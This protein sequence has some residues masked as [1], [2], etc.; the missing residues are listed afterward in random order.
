[1]SLTNRILPL[2]L[3]FLLN[4]TMFLRA[5]VLD[6]STKLVYNAGTTRY[7]TGADFLYLRANSSP[8]DT[9]I[10]NFHNYQFNY[11]NGTLYQDLGNLGTALRRVYWEQASEPGRQLGHDVFKD[12][13][14]DPEKI[15]LYNT[16]SPFTRIS[17]VQG[18]RGLQTIDAEFSRNIKPNWNFGFNVRRMVALK[19][20]GVADRSEQQFSNYGFQVQSNFT[21]KSGKYRNYIWM[22]VMHHFHFETGGILPDTGDTQDQMFDYKLENIQL[23]RTLSSTSRLQS[24]DRRTYYRSYQELSIAKNGL[25]VFHQLDFKK[26]L[27]R[28]QD[29]N[30][31]N[32]YNY[33]P[34]IFFDSTATNDQSKYHLLENKAGVKGLIGNVYYQLFARH[35]Y[36]LFNQHLVDTIRENKYEE[37]FFGGVVEY[38]RSDSVYIGVSAESGLWDFAYAA[39]LRS[40]ILNLQ[41]RSTST[42]AGIL[43]ENMYSNHAQWTKT[44]RNVNSTV[45]SASAVLKWKGQS[46]TPRA[47]YTMLDNLIYYDTT[48]APSQTSELISFMQMGG[49][50]KTGFRGL[51]MENELVYT[52]TVGPDY[53]PVPEWFYT[54]R[55]YAYGRVF[56]KVLRLQTG[57][58]ATRTSVYRTP[59]YSALLQQ[60]YLTNPNDPLA[61]VG[62]YWQANVFLNAYLKRAKFFLLVSHANQNFPKAGYFKTPYYSALGRTV[63]FGITWMFY[64]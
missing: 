28:Y 16:R 12:Y 8:I 20:I 43:Q 44:F 45:A 9:N 10:L 34:A 33:Y 27:L 49:M 58:E 18:S 55:I 29:N 26:R 61:R 57:V 38:R 50:L 37:L 56:K 19:Q 51:W 32:N 2:F 42:S 36:T 53:W 48:S 14:F 6:D 21:S 64:D 30:L 40:P 62:S 23:V 35:R 46:F 39:Y 59:S 41:V 22:D 15:P 24:E 7:L 25:Q 4:G 47:S 60:F 5:Q 17:Y 13:M 3:L 11:K 31:I 63:Q 52:K 54:G 1:M